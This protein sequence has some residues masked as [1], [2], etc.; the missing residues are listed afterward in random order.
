MNVEL[1]VY[2]NV[3]P[4]LRV[5]IF[6]NY[7][8]S[9]CF[10]KYGVLQLFPLMVYLV[11]ISIISKKKRL[12]MRREIANCRLCYPSGPLQKRRESVFPF[13]DREIKTEYQNGNSCNT[14]FCIH[15]SG[16]EEVMQRFAKFYHFSKTEC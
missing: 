12:T 4:I 9:F 2:N 14:P 13:T 5:L 15:S 11:F 6:Y 1:K 16:S 7:L 3:L 10:Q 8:F